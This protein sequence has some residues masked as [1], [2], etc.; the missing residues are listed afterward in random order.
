MTY[1]HDHK[2]RYHF[3]TNKPYAANTCCGFTPQSVSPGNYFIGRYKYS[4]C[5]L[6][7]LLST[8]LPFTNKEYWYV[9]AG[10]SFAVITSCSLPFEAIENDLR[11]LSFTS[12]MLTAAIFAVVGI[13]PYLM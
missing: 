9:P 2:H 3:I 11:G 7:F 10:N 1:K 8:L 5:I 6:I 12:V 13:W 4:Y